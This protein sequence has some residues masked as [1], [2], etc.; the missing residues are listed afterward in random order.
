M[1]LLLSLFRKKNGIKQQELADFL[2]TSR[3]FLSLIETG[4]SHCPYDKI[5]KIM[6]EGRKEKG[7]DV[8][9]LNPSYYRL[10]QL[11]EELGPQNDNCDNGDYFNWETGESILHVKSEDMLDIKHGE[12]E[13]TPEISGAIVL[14]Y[15]DVNPEWLQYGK[16]PIFRK[17]EKRTESDDGNNS[18]MAKE[19]SELKKC[20]LDLSKKIEQLLEQTP[21]P[22]QIK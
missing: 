14:Q 1:I 2:G 22:Q 8:S 19:L 10:S 15:P 3:S 16:G 9:Y 7:W 11:C 21:R 13:I 17:K 12:K 6:N 5:D 4:R 18:K 20:V